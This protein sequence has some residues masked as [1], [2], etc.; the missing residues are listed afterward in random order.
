M[1]SKNNPK[2]LLSS[3]SEQKRTWEIKKG[4]VTLT[5]TLRVDIQQQLKDFRECAIK[6]ITEIDDQIALLKG[7]K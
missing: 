2:N 3:T 5:F 4:D 7:K 6:A 1:S